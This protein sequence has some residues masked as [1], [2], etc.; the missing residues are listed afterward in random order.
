MSA[1]IEQEENLYKD[2][3]DLPQTEFPMRGN[4]ALRE[5]EFQAKWQELNIYERGL[6]LRKKNHAQKFVLHD[7]PPYLSSDKIHIGT[8]LNKILKDIVIK[9]KYQRGFY[10]PYVPGYDSHGLPIENAVVQNIKGGRAA[11]SVVELREKCKEFALNNLKGQEAKFK[12]LGILGDWEH[13]YITLDPKFEA[14]QIRLFSEMADKGYIYRGLKTV[15]WSYGCETALADAEVEYN[16]EHVSNAIYVKFQIQESSTSKLKNFKYGDLFKDASILIWTTTPWTIPAS[17]AIAL[18]TDVDYIV[19]EAQSK[20]SDADGKPST[21]NLGRLIIAKDL[22]DSIIKDTQSAKFSLTLKPISET[23][24]GSELEGLVCL[25]P[26]FGRVSPVIFGKH[27]TTDAG[28]GCVHTAP[29]HGHEDFEVGKK[30]GLDILC[31]VDGRGRYTKEAGSYTLKNNLDNIKFHKETKNFQAGE[32]IDLTDIH[33]INEGNELIIHLLKDA[34]ALLHRK[35]I[36]H[37]YPYCWRSKTPLLYRATEQWFA[38]IDGF[39]EKALAAIDTV[40]WIPERGRNRIYAMIQE[41]GDWCI[42]R[43][44]TWGVPIPA[45]YDADSKDV[46]GNYQAILDQEIIEQVAKIIGEEGS[47]A[48][49]QK[50]PRDLLPDKFKNRNFIKETD[51]MDVWFD[52]GSTHRAVIMQRP[53]LHSGTKF[54]PAE[55]YLEGSDQHRGWFQSSLL[56]SVA[57]NGVAPYK[58][59][60]THGF[61]MDE[62]GRKMSKSLSNVVDPDKVIQQYGADI[63]RLWVA[64]VDYSVDIKVGDNMFKQLSDIYRNFRNTSRYMLGNLFDFDPAHDKLAYEELWDLDRLILHRLQILVQNLTECFDK[65]QFFKY[66]QLIQNFCSVDL[67]AFYFDIIKDRLYTHGTKSKSRRAAQTVLLELLSVLNRAFVPVLPHLAEDIYN[68]TPEKIKDHYSKHTDFF[69]PGI[70]TRESI[71]LSNWP[72]SKQEYLSEALSTK[73]NSILSLRDL[74]NKE[75][76]ILRKEKIIGKSL[77]ASILISAPQATIDML[78]ALETEVTSVLIVSKIDYKSSPEIKIS[79]SKFDSVKCVRCWKHF[80]AEQIQA[81]ICPVCTEAVKSRSTEVGEYQP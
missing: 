76:E 28:T 63:L 70:E 56:T 51:T 32:T 66:Y 20:I 10:T 5:P 55:M 48:W 12:R 47:S 21:E 79:A 19:V 46:N 35:K 26:M 69:D 22:M 37:S 30:Y 31:P 7:G 81:G 9:Y 17:L 59:V 54:D 15:Y 24:K 62:Q 34:G 52:S 64:S 27:V 2:T 40:E 45:F 65:Y 29:G 80:E 72:K 67:S 58:S 41:R 39:R 25:H 68:F 57:V 75:I 4:G 13:P 43:Q 23:F 36:T 16:E 60:L 6:K 71:L 50:E 8:A 42:S 53:E 11:V 73:W 78:R 3:I 74:V 1:P 18:N 33:T 49:Y 14:E 77:E 44:R 61:V 38:S